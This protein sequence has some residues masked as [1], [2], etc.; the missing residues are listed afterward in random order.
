MANRNVRP[1]VPASPLMLGEG[2]RCDATPIMAGGG[3]RIQ[4]NKEVKK[5]Q[6]GA[7]M[8]QKVVEKKE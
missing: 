5:M 7:V 3:I 6:K 8:F 4:N 2:R 1:Q